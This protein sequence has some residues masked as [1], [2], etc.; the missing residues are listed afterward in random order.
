VRALAHV[1]AVLAIVFMSGVT[2][3]AYAER[4][5][6]QRFPPPGQLV[7]A[8]AGQ[9]IHV[10]QWGESNPG[11][12]IVLDVSAGM[13]ST[14]WAW[15]GPGIAQLGHRVLAFDRPGMAWSSGP[16]QP[17]D[18]RHAADALASALQNAAIPG[19]YVIVGHSYGG[20]S[21]RVFAGA[22]RD[23]V[24]GLVLLDTT[25][26]DGGGS[27]GFA[28]TWRVQAWLAH[29]GLFELMPPPNYFTLLPPDEADAAYAVSQW[30]SHLDTGAEELEAWN[31]SAEQ[32]RAVS[33]LRGLPTLIVSAAG[34]GPHLDLQR[35]LLNVS[36]A[37]RLIEIDADH[38][39]MLVSQPQA[40]HVIQTIDDFVA[41]S[42]GSIASAGVLQTGS[43]AA[44]GE[45]HQAQ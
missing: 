13:P 7:D 29:V 3:Q 20:F 39:G 9:L 27:V 10:R 8:G 45:V 44:N 35:D 43:D 36:S 34:G 31:S 2:V 12:V 14:I 6:R 5:E 25:H 23:R 16:W 4:D 30:T 1:L 28:T 24:V 37:S 15:V 19:P 33:D 17:R 41:S 26:P 38:M 21:S 32:I 42:T 40:E 22:Y 11:P 18:A